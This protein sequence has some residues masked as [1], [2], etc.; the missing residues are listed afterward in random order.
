MKKLSCCDCCHV[1]VCYIYLTNVN[2]CRELGIRFRV[3]AIADICPN[4]FR[5]G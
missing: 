4:F 2:H 3:S 1:R 5:G